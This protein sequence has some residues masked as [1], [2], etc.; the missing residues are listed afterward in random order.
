M[1]IR[2]YR[3]W[4]G[5]VWRYRRLANGLIKS[6]PIALAASKLCKL[7]SWCTAQSEAPQRAAPDQTWV[8]EGAEEQANVSQTIRFLYKRH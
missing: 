4:L 8:R 5:V 7:R 6:T 3:G 2:A 1:P